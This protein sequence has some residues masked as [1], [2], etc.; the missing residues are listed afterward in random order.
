[1]IYANPQFH[2]LYAASS[3]L[4]L[5]Y[6]WSLRRRRRMAERFAAR[7]ILENIAPNFSRKRI[8][9]KASLIVLAALLAVFSLMRP[10]WGFK[11]EE[12]KSRGLDI[13][14][15]MD[16]SKSMLARDI[17]P[18]RL[19]RAKLAVKEM[20]GKL[21]SDRVGLIAFSG[22]AFLQAPL[23]TDYGGFLLALDDLDVYSIPRPGTNITAAIREAIKVLKGADKDF[24][25]MVIITDG[26]DLEGDPIRASQEARKEGLKIFC[27]GAGTPEGELIPVMSEQGVRGFL[28]DP[29]GAVVKSRLNEDVLKKVALNTGGAYV[30]ATG[31]DFGLE[32]LYDK[33][34]SKLE[35]RELE[36][37][38]RKQYTE[39][40]QIFL[41]IALAILFMEP[42]IGER[43]EKV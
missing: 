21:R 5:F 22:S 25:V 19:H 17:K 32:S 26:E 15:A 4:V 11:W 13:L 24:K 20:V 42:F 31:A 9:F 37:R 12:V 43:R 33:K 38:M 3:A 7:G 40:F 39:R 34:I 16:T 18:N 35:K 14:V 10:Q 6:A 36:S 28:K 1:M 2:L 8:I 30:R 23:T 27:V 29:S 41:A